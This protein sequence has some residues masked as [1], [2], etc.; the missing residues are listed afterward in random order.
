MAQ[1]WAML[2]FESLSAGVLA[3]FVGFLAVLAV[4]GAYVLIVWPLTFWDLANLGLEQ[5]GSWV[6]PILWLVFAAGSLVG[7]AF[8]SGSVFKKQAKV[9]VGAAS[10]RPRR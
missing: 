4:V 7:Y 10:A 8:F 3:I 9:P 1:H 5:Y 6:R 2:I